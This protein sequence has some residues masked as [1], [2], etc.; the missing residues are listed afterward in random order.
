MTFKGAAKFFR[1]GRS[2]ARSSI[3]GVLGTIAGDDT[4][5]VAVASRQQQAKVLR[6]IFA[7]FD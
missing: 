4:I 5:F 7:L 2:H 3:P 6:K 1:E